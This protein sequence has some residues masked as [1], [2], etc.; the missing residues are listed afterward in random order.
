[1]ETLVLSLLTRQACSPA[2]LGTQFSFLFLPSCLRPSTSRS[3]CPPPPPLFL[4]LPPVSSS[5]TNVCLSTVVKK[6]ILGLRA[7]D[8][9]LGMA[10]SICQ[11][12]ISHLPALGT[13]STQQIRISGPRGRFHGAAGWHAAGAC[14]TE[15][16]AQPVLLESRFVEMPAPLSLN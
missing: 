1:M 15:R 3:P 14:H 2:S 4:P 9:R 6:E 16:N 8:R 7:E 13:T 5:Y 10:P 12:W 11:P